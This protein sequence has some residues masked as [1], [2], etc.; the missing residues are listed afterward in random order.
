M[1]KIN[2]SYNL[3]DFMKFKDSN[4]FIP[5]NLKPL[6]NSMGGT[7][8][9]RDII[10]KE[11]G[12]VI[13]TFNSGKNP[14][15]I[16]FRNLV[17][18]S[19]NKVN[20]RNYTS[21]LET[22]RGLNFSNQEHF[23]TFSH[24]IIVR[25]MNDITAIKGVT[26]PDGQKSLSEIYADIISEF[27]QLMIK[28]TN[29]DNVEVEVKFSTVLLNN[30]YKY[31]KDFMDP[32]KLLDSNNQHRADNYKGFMNF[33]GILFSKQILAHITVVSCLTTIKELIFKQE[34]VSWDSATCENV[35]DGYKRILGY[36]YLVFSNRKELTNTDIDL[37][38]FIIDIHNQ[39]K[40]RNEETKKLRKFTMMAHKDFENKFNKFIQ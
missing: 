13:D 17:I 37:I 22:L 16:I 21:V 27:S 4:M 29:K 7:L 32:T 20:Q 30:C 40:V 3:N 15:D 19:L 23:S 33:L 39:I 34:W 8:I 24:D 14:N 1:A 18:E 2:I 36:V 26:M 6:C 5:Q 28:D 38:K 35:Y 31:F 10:L 9:I 12:S 11:I 25:A